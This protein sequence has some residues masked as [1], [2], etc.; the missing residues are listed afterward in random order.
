MLHIPTIKK[1]FIKLVNIFIFPIIT[2]FLFA[3]L[4]HLIHTIEP[5]H[6]SPFLFLILITVVHSLRAG[7]WSGVW[8]AA[9]CLFIEI[10][11]FTEPLYRL[12][13]K[14]YSWFE[15]SVL[16]AQAVVVAFIIDKVAKARRDLAIANRQNSRSQSRLRSILDSV[17]AYIALLTPDGHI[18]EKNYLLRDFKV[19]QKESK[20]KYIYEALPWASNPESAEN[21]KKALEVTK[22]G[23][24]AKYDDTLIGLNDT[25]LH[26][27]IDVDPII[28]TD[29]ET[30]YILVSAID[31]T[32]R[33]NYEMD[34][35]QA[36]DNYYKLIDSNI[37][38]MIIG[39]TQGNIIETNGAFLGMMG[40]SEQEL[41]NKPLKL[42]DIVQ[43]GD[44]NS[45]LEEVKK[46]IKEGVSKP[47]QKELL[48]KE[49]NIVPVIISSVVIDPD[50]E[51]YL[52][53]IIDISEQKK[54]ER[55][56]E[57]FI[58]IV[59]HELK[60]PLTTLK[61]YVQ[62]MSLNS[63]AL[64]ENKENHIKVMQK[65]IT[66][67]H[68]L[69]N[70]LVDVTKID[71]N[72]LTFTFSKFDIVKAT[73]ETTAEIN[74]LDEEQEIVFQSSTDSIII[75]GDEFRLVQ[76]I[77]NFLTNAMKYSP[78]KTT[79]TVRVIEDTDSVTL[80]VED[81]GK[82]IDPEEHEHVFE[83]F[84]QVDSKNK[85]PSS[86]GL[87]LFISSTIIKNHNGTV[88]VRSELKKGSTFW[89]KIP[90]EAKLESD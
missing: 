62:L 30:E 82:G 76:V 78:D 77:T 80:E 52:A 72:K 47:E 9:V 69:V 37:I 36:T 28:N 17:N 32:E 3:F 87:G 84:Y 90:K 1:K 45:E 5:L 48:D 70:D 44:L 27:T 40:Y 46:I 75:D 73:R 66:K 12:E 49:G 60:T 54:L 63:S 16:F 33:K 31:I 4:N 21:L 59:G 2:S 81:L 14:T 22:S 65:Q 34:L 79:I 89:F 15:F 20:Y 50:L 74:A 53:V 24:G 26:V 58:S 6:G 25:L 35:R 71:N 7:F 83:K 10:Y 38:G 64:V 51:R 18:V 13:L 8:A 67:L 86:L 85:P 56:K 39:D 68:S 57:E 41:Q 23:D 19:D 55:K 61:G 29:G 43:P 88:G 11:F 42:A